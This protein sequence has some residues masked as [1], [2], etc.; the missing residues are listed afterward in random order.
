VLV[1]RTV[2][3]RLI[4]APLG[5]DRTSVSLRSIAEEREEAL[6]PSIDRAP[7]HDQASLRE[8][9]NN[10]GV[11]QAVPNVPTDCQRN[12]IIRE[13]MVRKRSR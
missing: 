12:D 7:V 1:D 2:D 11:A 3:I 8:P 9:L 4:N 13:A 6:D 5:A 10:I